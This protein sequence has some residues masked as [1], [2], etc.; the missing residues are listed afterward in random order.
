MKRLG[1]GLLVLSVSLVIACTGFAQNGYQKGELYPTIMGGYDTTTLWGIG[2]RDKGSN[3]IVG[4]KTNFILFATFR[5]AFSIQEHNPL[6][7]YA[8]GGIGWALPAYSY[9]LGDDLPYPYYYPVIGGGVYLR[10][11]DHILLDIGLDVLITSYGGVPFPS[12]GV[13]FYL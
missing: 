2:V 12:V 1:I 3:A 13:V 5:S 8:D 7:L 6:M 11:R 4:I 9:Y 10:L